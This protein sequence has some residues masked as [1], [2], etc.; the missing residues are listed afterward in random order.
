MKSDGEELQPSEWFEHFFVQLSGLTHI[1]GKLS[2]SANYWRAGIPTNY[3][4][5]PDSEKPL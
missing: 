2:C 5:R 4:C 3:A 1:L